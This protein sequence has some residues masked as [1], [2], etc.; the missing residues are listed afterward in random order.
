MRWVQHGAL[1]ADTYLR[2]GDARRIPLASECRERAVSAEGAWLEGCY[3][4]GLGRM[5]LKPTT[6]RFVPGEATS[7]DE[8]AIATLHLHS[9]ATAADLVRPGARVL[10]VGFGEGYGSEILVDAGAEYRGIEPDPVVVEHARARYGPRFELYDGV[11]IPAP[12]ASF[13]LV[14][15]FQ[16]I[17]LLPDPVVVLRELRRVLADDGVALLTTPNRIYRLA[18]G[19]RPWN[20]H[21]YREYTASELRDVLGS[22]FSDVKVFGV[23]AADPIDSLVK[24]RG[25][26]ARRLA[27]LDPL[28][29][30]HRLPDSLNARLRRIM[31]RAAQPD[32]D[33]AD[34]TID[35]VWHDES[36][37]EL[38]LD[39]F[40]VAR[41]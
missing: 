38:G 19:Q 12:D 20:R 10:D 27:R 33:P 35:R 15:A 21:H 36:R 13:D 8:L 32:V 6:V 34:F 11:S 18:D 31:R 17:A 41:L 16:V 40:G 39:L 4:T 2:D 24:A 3:P 1:V 37:A 29:L 26:R 22:V 28:G 25:A 30:H 7:A 9:Y 23:F 5:T 14:L